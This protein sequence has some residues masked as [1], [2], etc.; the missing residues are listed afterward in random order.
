MKMKKTLAMVAIAAGVL[1]GATAPVSATPV[2]GASA[3]GF[4]ICNVQAGTF[5]VWL[6]Q[7]LFC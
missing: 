5:E 7:Q 2:S 4:S 1:V 3:S 6:A